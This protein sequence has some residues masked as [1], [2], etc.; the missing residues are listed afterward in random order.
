MNDSA[1]CRRRPW[2][3]YQLDRDRRLD[4]F[5]GGS[6]VAM[7]FADLVASHQGDDRFSKV[8]WEYRRLGLRERPRVSLQELCDKAGIE[9]REF[10]S[11]II[12]FGLSCDADISAVLS[13]IVDRPVRIMNLVAL[14]LGTFPSTQ[15]TKW[16]LFSS[17]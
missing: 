9:P 16:T 12:V 7:V 3:Q 2:T 15:K 17:G 5:Q 14:A 4:L 11:E 8:A 13:D 1:P 10:T 6:S